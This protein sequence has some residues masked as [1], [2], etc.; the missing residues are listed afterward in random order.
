MCCKTLLSKVLNAVSRA[1]YIYFE[2][3]TKTIIIGQYSTVFHGLI[4]IFRW[5]QFI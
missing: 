3:L 2:F 1:I 4:P 5:L